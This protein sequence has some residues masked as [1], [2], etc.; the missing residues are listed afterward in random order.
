MC[1][2]RGRDAD[3]GIISCAP[4]HSGLVDRDKGESMFFAA[5]AVMAMAAG[6]PALEVPSIPDQDTV[7]IPDTKINVCV[8]ATVEDLLEVQTEAKVLLDEADVTFLELRALCDDDPAKPPTVTTPT[9]TRVPSL[10]PAGDG[11]IS[12]VD[13]VPSGAP[14]TGDGPR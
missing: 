3:G 10:P 9:P 5:A 14:E 8:Y 13:V 11:E 2:C 12:Q 6:F 7:N 1:P 4:G